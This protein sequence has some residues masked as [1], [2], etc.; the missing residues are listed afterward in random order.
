MNYNTELDKILCIDKYIN[1]SKE[2]IK[3]NNIEVTKI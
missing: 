3:S 2:I 1:E